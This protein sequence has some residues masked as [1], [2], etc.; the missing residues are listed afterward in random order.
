[1]SL[2]VTVTGNIFANLVGRLWSSCLQFVVI[3]LVAAL[4]GPKSYG[5]IGFYATILMTVQFLNQG[6]SSV[7]AQELGRL[8]GRTAPDA[9]LDRRNLLRGLEMITIPVGTAAGL[10]I[11]L[12]AAPVAHYWLNAKGV[13]PDQVIAS[14]RLMGLCLACQWPSGLYSSGYMGLHRQVDLTKVTLVFST[15]QNAGAVLLLWLIAPRP[16]IFFAWQAGTWLIFN[17][18]LRA[19]LLRLLGPAAAPAAVDYAQLRALWSF[20]AGTTLVALTGSLL[21]QADKLMVSRYMPLDQFAAYSL[22]FSIAS[23]IT[24]LVGVPVASVL[25]PLLSSLYAQDDQA[26]LAKEYHHWTQVVAFLAL[27]MGGA[28]IAFPRPLLEIWLGPHSPLVPWMIGILPWIAAGTLLNTMVT[29]PIIL[30]FSVRWTRLSIIT[31][32]IALPL[33][34]AALAF[35]LPRFGLLAGAWCW[36]GLNLGYYLIWVPLT[37]RRLLRGELWT[38]WGYDTLLPAL[39]TAAIFTASA[40]LIEIGPSRWLGLVQASVTALLAAAVLLVLL[41]YP[42]AMAREGQRRLTGWR[43]AKS[44]S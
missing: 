39:A 26:R 16:E 41:P 1:L 40:R 36:L 10:C 9:R 8:G 44:P 5:L 18:V 28:L 6:A 23:L 3:P 33:F 7:L 4:L 31:N 20:G 24:M 13:P 21:S 29:T 27:P 43:R 11:A 14:L 22:C 30:Q 38:W 25:L 15:V 19:R 12:L 34:F 42:R 17:W 37:H 2:S 35:G 32:F